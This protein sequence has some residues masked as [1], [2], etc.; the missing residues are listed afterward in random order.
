MEE[1]GVAEFVSGCEALHRHPSFCSNEDARC[2]RIE[3][4]AKQSFQRTE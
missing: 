1:M 2:G 3:I 4:G